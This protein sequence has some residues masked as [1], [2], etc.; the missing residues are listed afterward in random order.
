LLVV[1]AIIAILSSLLLPA[2]GKAREKAR[3]TTC[4]GNLKQV[5]V[6]VAMYADD[7]TDFMPGMPWN[8][9]YGTRSIE[10]SDLRFAP[11]MTDYASVPMERGGPWNYGLFKQPNNVLTCPSKVG[12][13]AAAPGW[14]WDAYPL[15]MRNLSAYCFM[16]F[17]FPNFSNGGQYLGG[18]RLTRLAENRGPL[19]KFMMSDATYFL[20]PDGREMVN[21]N[22]GGNFL[23]ADGHV[24]WINYAVCSPANTAYYNGTFSN[25]GGMF[26]PENTLAADRSSISGG[27]VIIQGLKVV[28]GARWDGTMTSDYK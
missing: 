6:A 3:E 7:H 23:S 18:T 16:G 24:T 17:G 26:L 5:A 28:A 14:R 2:L 4:M 12:Q 19:A 22:T 10:T 8:G 20:Q 25:H 21:H 27:A 1:V 15:M 9:Y 11:F 13:W